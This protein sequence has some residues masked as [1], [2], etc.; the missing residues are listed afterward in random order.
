MLPNYN[1]VCAE[2]KIRVKSGGALWLPSGLQHVIL[3]L[4]QYLTAHLDT[5]SKGEGPEGIQYAVPL[6]T[7]LPCIYCL[8]GRSI[9]FPLANVIVF[10]RPRFLFTSSCIL[11]D[12]PISSLSGR[13][14]ADVFST[15]RGLGWS[16]TASL[17]DKPLFLHFLLVPRILLSWI[18]RRNFTARTKEKLPWKRA[19]PPS[20]TRAE[21]TRNQCGLRSMSFAT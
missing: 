15:Y 12:S 1:G 9:L 20:S 4:H 11:S 14:F 5:W 16:A 3:S 19:E 17:G 7:A 13:S 18:D 2:R 8:S 10:S 21:L 6:Q